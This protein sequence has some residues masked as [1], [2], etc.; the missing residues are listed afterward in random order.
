V[1]DSFL[2]TKEVAKW[3]GISKATVLRRVERREIPA[4]RL[5]TNQLRFDES[6]VRAQYL[7][8]RR[9]DARPLGRLASVPDHDDGRS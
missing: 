8:T 9:T 5:A 6:E 1:S 7:A 2:T 3:L 4:F